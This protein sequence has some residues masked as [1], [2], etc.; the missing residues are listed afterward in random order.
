VAVL[1]EFNRSSK[2]SDAKQ[3]NPLAGAAA[4]QGG[5]ATSQP[6]G[7][8]V[9]SAAPSP[10][11]SAG[12]SPKPGTAATAATHS[13]PCP[14]F[15]GFPDASCTGWQHTGVKLRTCDSTVKKAGTK[16]DGCRFT[17]GLV[18]QAGDVTITRSRVEGRVQGT[19]LTSFSLSNL[20][21]QDVEIDGGGG[22]DPNGQAAIGNDAYTCIRCDVHGTGRGANLGE[23]VHI[24]DS[25]FHDF[26][27]VNGAHQTAIGSNG[28]DK[29][30]IIHNNLVCNSDGCSA[31]LSLYGDFAPVD[32]ALIQN[33]LFNTTGSYCTY[34]G[35]TTAKPYP[36]GTNIRYIN[37][38]FGKKYGPK[39]GLFGPVATWEY[40]AGDVWTG[41]QWQ[42]GSGEVKPKSGT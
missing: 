23:N 33:N 25:Y 16:L 29:Y 36:H 26:V 28:G 40:Y 2:N 30:Q 1:V 32:D 8:A 42:D 19:Y 20:T 3:S 15:P 35:S 12:T 38:L 22:V 10:S 9:L 14:A 27:Y 21:L 41:N 7:K 31:A 11:S 4:S 18:I 39:C 13:G 37:N 5:A 34:G 6:G 24:E 17:D